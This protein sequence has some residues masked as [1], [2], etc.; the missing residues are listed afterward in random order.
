MHSNHDCNDENHCSCNSSGYGGII[1]RDKTLAV[2]IMIL[3][4]T[5][6]AKPFDTWFYYRLDTVL[7]FVIVVLSVSTSAKPSDT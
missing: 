4:V 6:S 3:S 7:A 1:C 2:I 5:I